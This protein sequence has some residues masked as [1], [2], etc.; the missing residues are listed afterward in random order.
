MKKKLKSLTVILY[1]VYLAVCCGFM[2]FIVENVQMGF[3]KSFKAY[4]G[5]MGMW[6][7]IFVIIA[8]LLSPFYLRLIVR[9][10]WK[11]PL[12]AIGLVLLLWASCFLIIGIAVIST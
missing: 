8:T 3:Y 5:I 6:I 9:T 11:I 4:Y 7:T 1:I 2:M 10:P 12:I